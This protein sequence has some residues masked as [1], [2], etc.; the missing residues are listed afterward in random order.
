MKFS[1]FLQKLL[2]DDVMSWSTVNEQGTW[3]NKVTNA[4]E[5]L[6]FRGSAASSFRT[7]D[8]DDSSLLRNTGTYVPN[9]MESHPRKL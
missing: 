8:P 6:R 4:Y 1:N 2:E 3:A 5:T 7:Q 9:Y